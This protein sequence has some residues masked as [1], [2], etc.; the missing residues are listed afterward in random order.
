MVQIAQEV[1]GSD[2]AV[3]VA[4]HTFCRLLPY[5]RSQSW[6]RSR[7]ITHQVEGCTVP[8]GASLIVDED[9][10]AVAAEVRVSA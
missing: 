10:L 9:M 6:A 7:V 8:A 4:A 3:L 1:A 2:T 5:I